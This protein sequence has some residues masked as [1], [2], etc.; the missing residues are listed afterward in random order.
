MSPIHI[1][2]SANPSMG[3]ATFMA[4]SITNCLV[5]IN[6]VHISTC[7]SEHKKEISLQEVNVQSTPLPNL[8]EEQTSEYWKAVTPPPNLLVHLGR[9]NTTNLGGRLL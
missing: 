5:E 3:K 7:N 2:F 9:R 1:D 4:F 6:E 8:M